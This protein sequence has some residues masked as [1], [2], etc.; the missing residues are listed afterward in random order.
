MRIEE[1]MLILPA[2]YAIKRRGSATTSDL[3]NDLTI[4]FN[5]VGEDAKILDGRNDTKFSQKVRNLVSHR[6]N[7]GMGLYT[8]FVN[9]I[10]TLTA[11]GEQFL[12]TRIDELNYFFS[13]KFMY[14]DT[15]S[16]SSKIASKDQNIFLY[17]ENVVVNEGLVE[18]KHTKVR[19]RSKAL[20]DAAILY[21]SQ[22]GGLRCD[23]C[24]FCFSE[25]YGE[26]GDGFIEIHHIKPI[27]Q[28]SEKGKEMFIKEAV[29]YVRPLCSNCHR[30]IHRNPQKPLTIEELKARIL[31]SS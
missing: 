4:V 7:N 14:E 17:D 5:P 8:D 24:D 27:C 6:D 20:R 10:Y 19:A 25:K 16:L 28:Y 9:G 26:L 23:V 3:I 15:I 21:Y 13:Q 22:K 31:P 12:N 30:M 1:K 18:S 29:Q 11:S 2:L